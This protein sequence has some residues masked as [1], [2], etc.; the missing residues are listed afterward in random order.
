MILVGREKTRVRITQAKIGDC[1]LDARLVRAR[2]PWCA[3]VATVLIVSNS[4]GL[5]I[6][7]PN[8][9]VT[10]GDPTGNTENPATSMFPGFGFWNN[11]ESRDTYLGDGILIRVNH[12]G[13][14]PGIGSQVTLF[15]VSV[16]V[17]DRLRL[18]FPPALN[19][20]SDL[21]VWKV[22]TALALPTLY[23]ITQALSADD[24]V[25]MTGQ[26]HRRANG[27]TLWDIQ[28]APGPDNDTWTAG[29]SEPTAE[30]RG[31]LTVS[32]G[33]RRWGT[34]KVALTDVELGG[35]GGVTTAAFS[36]DF[37]LSNATAW[38]AQGTNNDS[39]GPVF[40][41][42]GGA[43]RLA[44]LIHGLNE[45]D[46]QPLNQQGV[47]AVDDYDLPNPPDNFTSSHTFISDL[48]AYEDQLTAFGVL[49]PEPATLSIVV[50]AAAV[51]MRRHRHET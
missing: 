13:A 34:N 50:L 9:L 37:S 39:S 3:L 12:T 51:F 28:V 31:F 23:P 26:G 7:D 24:D 45:F 10:F 20:D 36:T 49:I 14:P 17:E 19:D 27:R 46:G 38:E 22:D 33:V 48:S 32:E 4:D 41:F 25:I 16:T 43:W 1:P 18:K 5:M 11:T 35:S 42:Q 21:W 40:V 8:D 6:M 44:G 47:V 15:G 30:A 2:L 29:A